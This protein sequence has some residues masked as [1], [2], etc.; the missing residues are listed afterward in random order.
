MKYANIRE[1]E[2]KIKVRDDFF[3]E[4]DYKILGNIDFCITPKNKNPK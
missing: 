3:S 1:E 2:I 4:Y